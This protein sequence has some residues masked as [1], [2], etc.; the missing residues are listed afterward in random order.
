MWPRRLYMR[1]GLVDIHDLWSMKL[2]LDCWSHSPVL[3]HSSTPRSVLSLDGSFKK[4]VTKMRYQW[5]LVFLVSTT[6]PWADNALR[7]NLFKKLSIWLSLELHAVGLLPALWPLQFSGVIVDP[8]LRG[9]YVFHL[10][11][12]QWLWLTCRKAHIGVSKFESI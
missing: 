1:K 10:H 2:S 5:A 6:V 7:F 4:Q 12:C 9:I 11:R 3:L 8:L